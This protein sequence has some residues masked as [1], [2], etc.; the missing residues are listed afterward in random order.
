MGRSHLA[1]EWK[2]HTEKDSGN[3]IIGTRPVGKRGKIW[4]NAVKTDGGEILELRIWKRKSLRE[5]SMEVPFK[6]GHCS[7]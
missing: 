4:A 6:S 3:S 1:Y 7:T 5:A 2:S